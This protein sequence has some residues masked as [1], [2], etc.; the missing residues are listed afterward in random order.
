MIWSSS[1]FPTSLCPVAGGICTLIVVVILYW[2]PRRANAEQAV[3]HRN[4]EQ[5]E[6]RRDQEA[7]DYRTAERGILL[8]PFAQAERHRQHADDHGERRHADGPQ[9][10]G[11]GLERRLEGRASFPP[12]VIREGD[13]Q[14]AVC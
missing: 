5:G 11:A 7:A 1:V 3:R 2:Q 4:E 14:D 13:E 8:A 9:P 10:H 12:Q 6:E